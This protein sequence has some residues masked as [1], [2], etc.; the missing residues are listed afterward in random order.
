MQQNA[1][2]GPGSVSS[3]VSDSDHASD[4]GG[5]AAESGSMSA[6]ERCS[7]A[8]ASAWSSDAR[9]GDALASHSMTAE[10]LAMMGH[11]QAEVSRLSHANEELRTSLEHCRACEQAMEQHNAS[12]QAEIQQLKAIDR[13]APLNMEY[14]RNV[15]VKYIET[16]D[17]H[18]LVPVIATVLQLE[19]PVRSRVLAVAMKRPASNTSFVQSIGG[20]A[21]SALS[22]LLPLPKNGLPSKN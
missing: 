22:S 10:S 12:L 11:M 5:V 20:G 4:E 3:V 17:H 6:V 13:K 21:M 15:V 1:A 8:M 19:D 14:I 2:R 7:A 16:L 18:G 9:V